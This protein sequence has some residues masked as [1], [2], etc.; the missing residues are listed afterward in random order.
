[1]CIKPLLE[2]SATYTPH[3]DWVVAHI[4]SCFPG[5]I[6]ERVLAVGLREF[7]A[8]KPTDAGEWS[9]WRWGDGRAEIVCGGNDR[10]GG[11]CGG[12]TWLKPEGSLIILLNNCY[13][14]ILLHSPCYSRLHFK[15]TRADFVFEYVAIQVNE[16]V[17]CRVVSHI[18]FTMSYNEYKC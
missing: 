5:T 8:Q 11:Y 3:F 6:I 10:D 2:T 18:C 12:E 13:M 4:G 17:S 7:C 1:M 9:G 14:E 15:H 16:L